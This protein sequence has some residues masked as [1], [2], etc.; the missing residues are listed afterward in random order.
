[1]AID[2]EPR[3]LEQEWPPRPASDARVWLRDAH[4]GAV[5]SARSVGMPGE[6]AI[7][8]AEERL[9]RYRHVKR[10]MDVV[11]AAVFLLASLPLLIVVACAI[12]A[13]SSGPIFYGARR[14][15]RYGEDI[16]VLKFRSM[17]ADAEERLA[18]LLRDDVDLREEFEATYKLRYDPRQTRVGRIIRRTS[19]DELPQFWN[20]L[21]GAMSL[22]GP[23]P[24]TNAELELYEALPGGREAYLSLRPGITGLW[25]VSGRSDTTYEERVLLDLHYAAEC[26]MALDLLILAKTPRAVLS[27]AGAY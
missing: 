1:M 26:G 18:E 9:G 13:E 21:T 16:S 7:V 27:G 3:R 19:L 10:T 2:L 15:G 25:Q 17:F 6:A 14:V 5:G 4:L 20:V 24:I 23:R 8:A 22:V 12:R 11:L